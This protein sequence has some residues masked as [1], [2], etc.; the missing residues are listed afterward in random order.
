MYTEKGYRQKDILFFTNSTSAI[1]QIKGD[2]GHSLNQFYTKF[3]RIFHH[4]LQFHISFIWIPSLPQ[5]VYHRQAQ[6]LAK[7]REERDTRVVVTSKTH[8]FI[9]SS[10]SKSMDIACAEHFIHNSKLLDYLAKGCLSEKWLSN[11]KV[12][13]W[14][15]LGLPVR[16]SSFFFQSISDY[17]HFGSY[18]C[19]INI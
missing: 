4:S 2:K 11:S 7:S 9:S 5:I 8:D 3:V 12:S 16:L 6:V 18:K 15:K 17:S 10:I 19:H 14:L 13:R 1:N